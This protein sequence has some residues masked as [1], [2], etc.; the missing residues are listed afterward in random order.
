VKIRRSLSDIRNLEGTNL[1]LS[2]YLNIMEREDV[3]CLFH[4]LS[5]GKL[6]VDKTTLQDLR[7]LF[8]GKRVFQNDLIDE[9][10]RQSIKYMYEHFMIVGDGDDDLTSR[11][12]P[13]ALYDDL[14]IRLMYLVVSEGCNLACKYC[15]IERNYEPQIKKT[16]MT[17]ETAEMAVN[18]FSDILDR[19]AKSKQIIFYGG[20]PLLNFP[21]IQAAIR[22]IHQLQENG[23][24]QKDTVVS[25]LTNG[26]LLS[27][28]V[29]RYLYENGVEVGISID[30]PA[31]NHDAMRMYPDGK[32]SFAAVWEGIQNAKKIYGNSIGFSVVPGPHNLDE[33]PKIMEW[34]I[35]D[36]GCDKVGISLP[37]HPFYFEPEQIAQKIFE[38][39][40][41]IKKYGLGEDRIV[42][43]LRP[44]ISENIYPSD[45]G[46]IGGQIIVA[47]DGS[48]GVCHGFLGSRQFFGNNLASL[49][50][51]KIHPM[52]L[53]EWQEWSTRSPLVALKQHC[54]ECLALGLCGGGC[55]LNA[56][57]RTGSIF[58]M[59]EAFCR[60]VKTMLGLL[61]W[62]L[63]DK[64]KDG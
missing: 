58:G 24:L 53:N 44:L 36:V 3:A 20:E 54:Q 14:G 27:E 48:L 63:Y 15:F 62:Y 28:S 18:Y 5:L 8:D 33:L 41:V 60:Y 43:V 59:D 35:T 55:G 21:A 25:L 64:G 16:S 6:F 29:A 39:F 13:K 49:S 56:Y 40:M 51:R 38:S 34:L 22:K 47:S 50:E 31:K 37:T 52:Q 26:T 32:G 45:C 2:Q 11:M 23:S 9:P 12:A 61:L 42:R 57:Y 19:S 7:R 10:L 17:E 30:G 4:S 46:A 1:Q